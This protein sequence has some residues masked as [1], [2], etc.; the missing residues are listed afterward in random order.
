MATTWLL[1]AIFITVLSNEILQTRQAATNSMFLLANTTSG[2]L[3]G[4]VDSGP[5]VPVAMFAGIPYAKA[6]TGPLRFKAPASPDKWTGVRD[7]LVFGDEC[8]QRVAANDAFRDPNAPHS[9]DCLYLNVYTPT[10][11]TSNAPLPVMVFI[12]GGGYNSGNFD[13]L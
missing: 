6:P 8:L 2:T 9:E 10:K 3:R 1:Q 7:A 13:V 5:S 12:H 11:R 4:R